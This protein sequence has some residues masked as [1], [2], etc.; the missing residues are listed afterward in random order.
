VVQV[1]AN[2]DFCSAQEDLRVSLC[3]CSS[4]NPTPLLKRLLLIW[5][6]RNTWFP[7]AAAPLGIKSRRSP[8]IF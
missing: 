2:G 8:S 6:G 1:K 3:P 5:M 7:G 4:K